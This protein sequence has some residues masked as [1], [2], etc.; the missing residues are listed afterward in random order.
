MVINNVKKN[1]R[2]NTYCKLAGVTLFSICFV[3]VG[4]FAVRQASEYISFVEIQAFNNG[5]MF[6]E[7]KGKRDCPK[8][9][10]I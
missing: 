4:L 7:M 10:S 9:L 1:N 2:K 3:G 5:F 6:G 8:Y